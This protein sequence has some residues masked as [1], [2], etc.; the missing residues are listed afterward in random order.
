V[1]SKPFAIR[2]FWSGDHWRADPVNLSGTPMNG[3]GRT[4]EEAVGSLLFRLLSG[5]ADSNH[6]YNGG[7]EFCY[8]IIAEPGPE[9][10][11]TTTAKALYKSGCGLYRAINELTD[12]EADK[13]ISELQHIAL[14]S[15]LKE[16]ELVAEQSPAGEIV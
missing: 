15:L 10:S 8:S 1:S 7:L 11:Q 12:N 4:K 9:P 5:H 2:V 6:A 3:T 13:P 14:L 16:W